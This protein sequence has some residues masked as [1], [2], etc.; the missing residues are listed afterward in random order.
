M[1]RIPSRRPPADILH[2][3]PEILPDRHARAWACNVT[4]DRVG[5][6]SENRANSSDAGQGQLCGPAPSRRYRRCRSPWTETAPFLPPDREAPAGPR[7]APASHPWFYARSPRH[8]VGT[9]VPADAAADD[10]RT[11]RQ[12]LA[13]INW[14]PRYSSQSVVAACRP[15]SPCSRRRISNTRPE[16][17]STRQEY[18]R[19]AR[20]SLLRS[21]VGPYHSRHSAFPRPPG[22]AQ[23]VRAL[24]AAPAAGARAVSDWVCPPVCGRLAD[25][26][27]YRRLRPH[28]VRPLP[29]GRRPS[30]VSPISPVALS[31]AV[32]FCGCAAPPAVRATNS[33]T[34]PFRHSRAAVARIT[35]ARSYVTPAHLAAV[36]WD[37]GAAPFPA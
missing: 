6:L 8:G 3:L 12:S 26:Y 14:R 31:R 32:R 35:R 5:G 10:R 20:W 37:P 2:I 1:H 29:H 13:P 33:G 19:S 9:S 23:C 15:S 36:C 27:Q 24:S 18:I 4:E 17:L 28:R 16:S 34:C 21:A 25:R 22:R 30:R 11:S 7:I